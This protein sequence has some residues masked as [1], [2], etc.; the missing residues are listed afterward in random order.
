MKYT[1]TETIE[2]FARGEIVVV[3]DDDDRENEGDLIVAASYCTAEKMAFIIRNGCGIVYAPLTAEDARRPCPSDRDAPRAA[4]CAKVPG[5]KPG[6]SSA[7]PAL[8]EW[9]ST[10]RAFVE[11]FGR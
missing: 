5:I 3:T 4:M 8:S 2:A 7:P 11:I 9:V 10:C 1:V 6:Y